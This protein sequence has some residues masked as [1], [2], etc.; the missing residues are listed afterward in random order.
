MVAYEGN[1][2]HMKARLEAGTSPF[3]P[4]GDGRTLLHWAAAGGHSDTVGYLLSLSPSASSIDGRD[5]AGWTALC[6]AASAGHWQVVSALLDAGASP[7]V[8]NDSQCIPL[9]YHRGRQSVAE[10]LVRRTKDVDAQN[11]VGETPM[12]R[13][14]R[15]GHES[16]VRLLLGH[17]SH[18]GVADEHGAAP[19]PS[20][21]GS[22]TSP[23]LTQPIPPC[24]A[25]IPRLHPAALRL[26]A[27]PRRGGAP[28]DRERRP[29]GHAERGG[30]LPRRARAAPP[31]Q[32]DAGGGHMR[33]LFVRQR[34]LA[35][36]LRAGS[37]GEGC[38]LPQAT[39]QNG[40]RLDTR[41]DHCRRRP[42][43]AVLVGRACGAL[44]CRGAEV[45][46]RAAACRRSRPQATAPGAQ[47][48]R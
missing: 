6:C 21:R 20:Q 29:R 16:V 44:L 32:G 24:A 5:G 25:P 8:A 11:G 35:G 12:H 34:A 42:P 2:E 36:R 43:A 46:R 4:D 31:A 18:P 41:R 28:P 9:H 15:D 33:P 23:A 37:C 27:R 48:R 3:D 7:N 45:T 30:P 39:P 14:A 13:A 22:S 1:L 40:R 47:L 10:L 26:R 19:A 17:G 38:A